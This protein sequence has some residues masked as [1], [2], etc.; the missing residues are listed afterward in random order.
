[1]AAETD[2]RRKKDQLSVNIHPTAIVEDGAQLGENITVG[3]F[4]YV[5]SDATLGDGCRIHHRASI[6]GRSELGANV[7][8]F[9]G[10]VIGSAPQILGFKDDGTSRLTIGSGTTIREHVTIHSGSPA[11]GGVTS[12]GQD[13][14]L[15]VDVHIAHDCHVGDKCVF[16]N[17]VAL[18]GH[19]VVGDQV[20]MGGLAAIHQFCRVGRHA[21]VGGGA[22]VVA[23]II[24]YGSV[25]GNHAHLAGLNLTG[26]KRR[27][28]SRQT[29]HD[30]RAAYRL[31]FAKEGTFNERI[32]DAEE[33][34]RDCP[35]LMEIIEFIRS[36]KNRAL[37]LPE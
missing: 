25:I 1:M 24:P 23:D 22:I 20:W 12:V 5:G 17:N 29:I 16:A 3:A 18:G 27:G 2:F 8:V 34:Y 7:E 6:T 11:H 13:C 21:F 32:A 28:F 14:L 10:A 15:M 26:L 9:P 30:L 35:E 31:L 36:A 19:I 33:T 37:C 4:A